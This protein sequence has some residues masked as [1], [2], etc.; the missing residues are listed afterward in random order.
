VRVQTLRI[1]PTAQALA[2]ALNEVAGKADLIA[3][4]PDHGFHDGFYLKN[5]KRGFPI[6]SLDQLCALER[7]VNL[8][9]KPVILDA[10]HTANL[11][12]P[13]VE[14]NAGGVYGNTVADFETDW[15]AIKRHLNSGEPLPAYLHFSPSKGGSPSH[16]LEP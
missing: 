12:S 15:P 8:Q 10:C 1:E 11:E 7:T 13:F 9:G 16:H 2:T 14:M 4:S 6:I 3:V 5:G